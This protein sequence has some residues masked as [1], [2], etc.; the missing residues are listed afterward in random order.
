MHLPRL[1]A[2]LFLFVAQ[3]ALAQIT[4]TRGADLSVDA[5][6]DGR[7][8][9]DL[10]GDIWIVPGGGGDARQLTHNLRTAQRPRWS[11][12]AS[13]LVYQAIDNGRQGVWLYDLE[14]DESR[15]LSG[16][17]SVDLHPAWHPGGERIVI[18][19]DTA[20]RGFDL[21][22]LDVPTG[23]RWKLT[24]RE[25]DEAEPAWSSDG[26]DLVYIHRLGD[27]WSLILRRHSQS[28]EVLLRSTQKLAA[29][30]WRPDG[31]LI[32]FYQQGDRSQQ[33]RMIIL[34]KPRLIRTYADDE[35][36]VTS[37]VS[38]QDRHRMY[39]AANG[40][41][42]QRQFDAWKSRPL[43]F[44]ATVQPVTAAEASRDRVPLPWLDEP[45]GSFIIHASRLYDGV[46]QDYQFDKD[47]LIDG[48]RI[49]SV[50]AHSSHAGAITIDMGDLTV[51]PGFIDADAR[52]P[53]DLNA[54]HGPDLLTTG[55]TTIV[56]R[57]PQ[58]TE[59]NALW[60]G[61]QVPGPRL[62][63]A[64]EWQIGAVSRPELDITGAVS[65][66]R[67]TGMSSGQ[68]LATQLRTLQIAGLN[69]T[70][71]LRAVGVNAAAAMLADPYLGRIATGAAA[72]LVFVDGDPLAASD[73]ALHVV[74]VVR[75][76]RFFSVSG[77]I[78]RAK[79]AESV[80]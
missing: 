37:P 57:H 70:Q 5:S 29:P 4:I 50:R 15:Q 74:A 78:D 63:D 6:G 49:A 79:S 53:A 42:R 7:L 21:W 18:T 32:T 75:N 41:I 65:T 22:E 64:S 16:Q 19:S 80:D 17:S 26:R 60:S 3:F 73:D 76:G 68:A 13:Q 44:R 30:S 39:Y 1:A 2:L 8:A 9:I 48:G 38:W 23:L 77:L 31:S 52:L 35:G 58:A 45:Q 56:G 47:I 61:K 40:E 51:L 62:L 36:F 24:D 27:Y 69:P 33:L 11:P 55:I 59:F 54:S 14:S 66:S 12:D 25:G 10:R 43:R 67:A 34:A 71:S 20:G 46:S 28:E 72:D